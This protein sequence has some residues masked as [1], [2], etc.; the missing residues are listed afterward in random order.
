MERRRVVI[1]GVGMVTPLGNNTQETWE[2]LIKG[3]S[4]IG[5]L[6]RFNPD[7][8]K[9]PADFPRIAG[10]LKNFNLERLRINEKVKTKWLDPFSQYALAAAIEAVAD[11]GIK[12]ENEDPFQIGVQI[13]TGLGGAK[14]WEESHQ[15]LLE[16]GMERIPPRFLMSFLA[17]MAAGNVS[18][19][20]G[21]K[22][23]NDCHVTACAAGAH[24][25]AGAFDQIILNRAEI[26]IVGGTEATLTPLGFGGFDQIRAL[27]HR[28]DNPKAASRPFD[29][30]SDGFVM[31]EG[32]GILILEE[33]EHALKRGAKIYAELAGAGKTG[34]AYHYTEPSVEGQREC[35]R[36]ALKE[37]G[38]KIEEVDY[39]NAHGTSTPAGDP[40]ETQ[41]IK[42]LF[43]EYALRIAVSSTKSML[44]HL[45]GA[46]GAVEAI[47]TV[48]ALYYGEI[49][50]T[51]NLENPHP[52]CDLDY[53]PNQSRK[54]KIRVALSN[55]FGFGGT[56]ACLVF[57]Q[58]K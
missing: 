46:A 7:D 33:R 56:N 22:G 49:P 17:N 26:M 58:F 32:A 55:S 24:A 27:S 34:D 3:K 57:K 39:I 30:D 53:V 41:A 25:I 37:A 44:G 14:T 31:A 50:P 18:M 45:Q 47:I 42:E 48:L 15:T 20:F 23:P 11:A 28:N 29:K 10:E 4:G 36:V 35:M 2:N 12:M 16:K 40:V 54:A 6:T 38:V 43:G 13:G 1:T 19:Q 5:R 8:N 21:A 52:E 51:I 9:A